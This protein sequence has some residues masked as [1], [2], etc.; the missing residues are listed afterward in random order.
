MTHYLGLSYN[1]INKPADLFRPRTNTM[2]SYFA[3]QDHL[4]VLN[5]AIACHGY[6]RVHYG[7]RNKYALGLWPPLSKTDVSSS[8][9]PCPVAISPFSYNLMLLAHHHCYMGKEYDFHHRFIIVITVHTT[10]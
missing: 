5:Y 10:T 3:Q 8:S 9:A 1:S 6:C 7:Y 2:R 4:G